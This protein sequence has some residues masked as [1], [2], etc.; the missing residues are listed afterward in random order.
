LTITLP[1]NYFSEYSLERKYALSNKTRSEWFYGK[2]KSSVV[3][4]ILALVIIELGYNFTR[5]DPT[6]I[7]AGL[8][9]IIVF[10]IAVSLTSPSFIENNIYDSRRLQDKELLSRLNSL[11]LKSGLKKIQVFVMRTNKTSKVVAESSGTA[12]GRKISLSDTML[13]SYSHDEI[14]SIVG[15]ELGH[16]KNGHILKFAFLI[17]I[18]AGAAFIGAYKITDLTAGFIGIGSANSIIALP[19]LL[20]TF[21]LICFAFTPVLNVFSRWTERKCDEY[22]L[23]LVG[24]PHAYVSSIVKL[25]D[26]NLRYASPNSLIEFLFFDHPS[27]EKRIK[28]G[29]Q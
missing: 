25:T 18:I 14:E 22:E 5:I 3:I 10:I 7:L 1:F 20:L 26:Q 15:H 19:L 2:I 6:W 28:I 8:G 21:S 13:K 9:V 16:H 17:S 29:L 24:K 11:A 12:S 23:K 27:S 4:L